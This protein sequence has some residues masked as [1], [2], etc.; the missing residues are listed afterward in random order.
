MERL[1]DAYRKNSYDFRLVERVG[2]VAIY[3]QREPSNGRLLCY[4]VFI[5]QAQKA[6]LMPSG[7][8]S[9]VKEVPPSSTTWGELGFSCWTLE[10]AKVRMA[11][12]QQKL[13]RI[14]AKNAQI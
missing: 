8:T 10:A 2:D 3:E 11:E 5:I 13:E 9:V 14:A 4:E 1:P 6:A 12:L 7:R